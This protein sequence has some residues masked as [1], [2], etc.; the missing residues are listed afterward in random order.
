MP[1]EVQFRVERVIGNNMVLVRD[2]DAYKELILLGKGIGFS[3]KPGMMISLDD[4]RIEQRF[5]TDNQKEMTQ[6]QRLM[7][8]I[9]PK[10]RAVTDHIIEMIEAD[11]G[12]SINE[13]ARSALPSHIQFAVYRIK[14]S[15]EI[16][17]PFLNETKSLYPKEFEVAKKAG[18]YISRE[19]EL[20]VE[21]EEV[22]FLTLHV[23]SATQQVTVKELV[24]LSNT[25]TELVGMIESEVGFS[26]SRESMDYTRL[27]THLRFAIER[28]KLGKTEKNPLIKT[29]KKTCKEEYKLALK[30]AKV[31]E[32][33]CSRPVP[34]DETGYL[35][36]HLYR[37]LQ[38]RA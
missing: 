19:F 35:A 25:I 32:N 26:I 24:N 5:S 22:G 21:E 34:E 3:T 31:M 15:M 2:S 18:E 37:L 28:I 10:V 27:I 6:Y 4:P 11:F 30:L 38:Q 17:N 1:K 23:F 16:A 9:D 20:E 36:M 7:E 13:H 33:N 14:N 8:V 12:V 29:I